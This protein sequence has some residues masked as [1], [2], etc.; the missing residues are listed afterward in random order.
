MPVQDA[1][2]F[3]QR[4]LHDV[5]VFKGKADNTKTNNL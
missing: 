3:R 4:Q 5:I 1:A 2:L